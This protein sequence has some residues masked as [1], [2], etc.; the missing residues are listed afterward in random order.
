MSSSVEL[1]LTADGMPV[2]AHDQ[3]DLA[4]RAAAH[5]LLTEGKSNLRAS[6]VSGSHGAGKTTQLQMMDYHLRKAGAGVS[7]FSG[8]RH[9]EDVDPYA[10]MLFALWDQLDIRGNPQAPPAEGVE[11]IVATALRRKS[12]PSA[13]TTVRAREAA[14]HAEKSL[15]AAVDLISQMVLKAEPVTELAAASRLMSE[16][17]TLNED[18]FQQQKLLE[19]SRSYLF[20]R[21]FR[22][23]MEVL[24]D[25]LRKR[26]ADPHLPCFFFVDDLDRCPPRLGL[27]LLE[28]ISRFLAVPGLVIVVALDEEVLREWV[29]S[30]YEGNVDGR[31]YV[32]KLFDRRILGVEE[33][34]RMIWAQILGVEWRMAEWPNLLGKAHPEMADRA[35][36]SA[37][38]LLRIHA[39]SD[40]RKVR[41]TLNEVRTL[42]HD[43][44][45]FVSKVTLMPDVVRLGVL[46]GYLVRERHP[47]AVERIADLRLLDARIEVIEEMLAIAPSWQTEDEDERLAWLRDFLEL[48]PDDERE[49]GY[50]LD[51][52]HFLPTDVLTKVGAQL[53]LT[54]MGLR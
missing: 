17:A 31:A 47:R 45:E 53:V 9:K 24:V 14:E 23:Q 30:A 6:L 48:K 50:V 34:A 51:I 21:R 28:A 5:V 42:I 20:P 29:K 11:A 26:Q 19:R 13:T 32:D 10:S 18:R 33:R 27:S 37:T 41:R 38:R 25:H 8:W 1:Q 35:V 40:I 49:L 36:I 12:Y 22:E 16:A 3:C 4:A 15:L 54:G 52:R 46:C 7:W 2:F 44:E 43:A 39:G